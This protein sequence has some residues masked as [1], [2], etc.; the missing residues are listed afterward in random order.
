MGGARPD[1]DNSFLAENSSRA[2]LQPH[3]RRAREGGARPVLRTRI[4]SR[5][6]AARLRSRLMSPNISISAATP[7][8]RAARVGC[9]VAVLLAVAYVISGPAADRDRAMLVG[10]MMPEKAGAAEVG[11]ADGK[12]IPG[13]HLIRESPLRTSPYSI[14]WSKNGKRLAA[15]SFSCNDITIWN[16]QGDVEGRLTRPGAF[17]V[18]NGLGFLNDDRWL[19]APPRNDNATDVLASVF[20]IAS[21]NVVRE[22]AG[23]EPGATFGNKAYLIAVSPDESVVAAVA[24]SDVSKV[25]P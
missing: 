21:G 13:L 3:S 18:G 10:W 7:S 14:V 25:E 1:I 17:Y 22:I 16:E 11:A 4:A 19:I 6:N 12:A 9:F 23:P 5:V 15:C 2:N 8:A 20:D 24:G